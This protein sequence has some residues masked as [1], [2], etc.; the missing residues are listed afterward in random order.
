[1]HYMYLVRSQLRTG[2]DRHE[3]SATP[4]HSSGSKQTFA[5]PQKTSFYPQLQEFVLVCDRSWIL[6]QQ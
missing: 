5:V 2:N 3:T 6:E 4:S 1:M